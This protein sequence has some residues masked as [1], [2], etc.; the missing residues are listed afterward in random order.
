MPELQ[1][2]RWGTVTIM[3]WLYTAKG[4]RYL[5][6]YGFLRVVRDQDWGEGFRSVEKW[7]LLVYSTPNTETTD[8]VV[9]L[10]GCQV[11]GVVVEKL[12]ELDDVTD[13]TG[14]T[15]DARNYLG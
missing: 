7:Q 3:D 10:P 12:D 13:P 15:M 4:C 5:S 1:K 9:V 6:V 14:A 8:P 11:R 2:E